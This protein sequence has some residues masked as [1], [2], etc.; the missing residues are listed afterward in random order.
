MS[1]LHR[2]VLYGFLLAALVTAPVLLFVAA[3]YGRHARRGWGPTLPARLGWL[4]MEA[5]SPLL[6][7][8]LA[9]SGGLPRDAATA[10]LVL[11]WEA[12]Y[13]HRAFVWPWRL[14]GQRRPMPILV[15]A[16]AIAFNAVNAWLNGAWFG[17]LGPGYPDDW[18]RDPRFLAGVALFLGGFTVNQHADRILLGL[19]PPGTSGYAVPQGGL[20][21]WVSCPNYLGELLEW[22]GFALAAWS[23]PALAF[24]VWTAANLVPRAIAHHRWYRRTFPEYPP[25]RRALLP[26]VL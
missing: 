10:V 11:L 21:R 7:A 6:F 4:L 15:V 18:I 26:G 9:L 20:F 25:E 8:A 19:R 16:M 24:A 14:R 17:G 1:P 12:H 2:S 22:C 3:P 5:P 13:L 23:P